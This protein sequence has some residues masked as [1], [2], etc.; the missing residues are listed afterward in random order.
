MQESSLRNVRKNYVKIIK[1][2]LKII[3]NDF[4]MDAK[5]AQNG[6]NGLPR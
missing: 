4:E 3:K 2:D 5:V 6:S 1:H